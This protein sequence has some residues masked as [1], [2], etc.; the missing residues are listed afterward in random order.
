MGLIGILFFLAGAHLL[1]QARRE[2][3]YW[4]EE[5]VRILRGEFIRREAGG[6]SPLRLAQGDSVA[7]ASPSQR[8]RGTLRLLGGFGLMFLGQVLLLIDLA[9]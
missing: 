2:V 4:L 7:A 5:F 8:G 6:V 1:W 9:F 3:R